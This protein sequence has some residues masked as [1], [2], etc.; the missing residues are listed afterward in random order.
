MNKDQFFKKLNLSLKSLSSEERKDILQ[1]FQEH[2]EI[3]RVEGKT[4]E[5]ISDSLGSPNHIAKELMAA[6]Y[7]E[8]VEDT[9]T[10]GNILRAM[11]AVIGLGF[12]NLVIVLGPFIALVSVI[13]AGWVSG[14]AFIISPLLVL[15]D[16]V[17]YPGTFQFFDL[18]FSIALTGLGLL[19]AIG[20][21]FATR[22]VSNGFIRYLNFNAKLVKGGLKHE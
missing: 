9:S 21:L 7:L 19:I 3:G 20:M 14:V 11:W 13:F 15:I 6:H 17:L 12:F 8:K 5:E 16:L 10:A 22:A 2:F 18:F 4:E 1:D